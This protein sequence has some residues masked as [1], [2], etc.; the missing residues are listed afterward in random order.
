MFPELSLS[1]LQYNVETGYLEWTLPI[2][3]HQLTYVLCIQYTPK[4]PTVP[5]KVNFL[6]PIPF[7]P[8]VQANGAISLLMFGAW[9]YVKTIGTLKDCIEDMM[10]APLSEYPYNNE[11]DS[12][13]RRDP[14]AFLAHHCA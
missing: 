14:A 2:H 6:A 4:Y 5:P 11:A 1:P 12:L 8:N 13:W 3:V 7:H 9:N 10:L